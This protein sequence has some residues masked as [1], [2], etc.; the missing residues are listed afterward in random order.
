MVVADHQTIGRGRRGRWWESPPG[1]G[2]LFSLV[3]R[4]QASEALEMIT[5]ALGVATAEAV[6]EAAGVVAGLKWPNDV[7]VSGRKLAGILVESRLSGGGI[8]GA[9]AGVGVN[10][11]WPPT[12]LDDNGLNATSLAALAAQD[13]DVEI[14][15]RAVL[16][17]AVL[18]R[19]ESLY[20]DLA[21]EETRRDVVRRA[22]N[23]SEILG[24]DISVRFADGSSVEG[25]ALDL[26]ATGAL[27]LE[28]T[29]GEIKVLN[30]GE[31]E[32]LRPA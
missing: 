7:T 13:A 3:L 29:D 2:L 9:V 23:R 31:T 1:S 10:V 25:R 18:K 32:R 28:T 19:F 26:T 27:R 6:E 17:G 15:D 16:L 8:E 5:T 22:A 14:P 4:P 24:Q 11:T 12:Q 21:G 20:D 30:V